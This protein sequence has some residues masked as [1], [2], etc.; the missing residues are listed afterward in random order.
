MAFTESLLPFF[1]DFGEAVT[2]NGV[3]ATAIFN[4][5]SELVLGDAVTMQPTLEL[6]ATVAASVGHVCVVRS[7]SYTVRQVLDQPP[8]GVIRQ[9]VLARS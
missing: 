1:T 6:P 5:S 3:A 2:V 8:D 7:V 9:L 4:S